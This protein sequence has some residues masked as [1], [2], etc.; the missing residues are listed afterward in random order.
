MSILSASLNPGF[1]SSTDFA[2]ARDRFIEHVA[3]R[4]VLARARLHQFAVFAQNAAESDVAKIGGVTFAARDLE[5]LFEMQSLRRADDVPNGVAL[6]IIDAVID[7][8]DVG[9][10][11]IE[12]AVALANDA[13]LV[14]QLRDVAKENDRPRLR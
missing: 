7:R 8:R 9:G 10:G 14:G 12:S 5:N 2:G 4:H 6:Q 11:V 1:F 3:Q 13:R